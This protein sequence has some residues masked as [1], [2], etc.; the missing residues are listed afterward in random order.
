MPWASHAMHGM[1]LCYT[2]PSLNIACYRSSVIFASC[3]T[4][5]G[6]GVVCSVTDINDVS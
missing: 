4:Y 6:A 3:S 1:Y 5:D 2:K